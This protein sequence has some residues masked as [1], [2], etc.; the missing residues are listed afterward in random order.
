M[1][2]YEDV[3]YTHLQDTGL[4]QHHVLLTR[5]MACRSLAGFQSARQQQ[6]QQQQQHNTQTSGHPTNVFHQ[7]EVAAE[8]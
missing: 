2:A 6:Q 8:S 4:Q 7:G 1:P 3:S 5:A